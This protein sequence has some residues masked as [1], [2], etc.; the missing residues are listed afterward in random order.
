MQLDQFLCHMPLSRQI[1]FSGEMWQERILEG[2][3]FQ[4][5]LV[6]FY[7]FSGAQAFASITHFLFSCN[8]YVEQRAN[9]VALLMATFPAPSVDHHLLNFL[10]GLTR[11]LQQQ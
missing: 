11:E 10:W 9:I 5:C 2:L 6:Q 8:M 3:N 7:L 1:E 4:S